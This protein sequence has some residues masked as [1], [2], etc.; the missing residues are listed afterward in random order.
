MTYEERNLD[1]N[2]LAGF[3]KKICQV[4]MIVLAFLCYLEVRKAVDGKVVVVTASTS[5]L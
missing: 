4:R 5:E 3:K 2:W 1:P